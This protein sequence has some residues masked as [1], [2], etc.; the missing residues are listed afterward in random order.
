MYRST[1]YLMVDAAAYSGAGFG[2]ACPIEALSR[3][4]KAS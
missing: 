3:L 4:E 1:R 2:G